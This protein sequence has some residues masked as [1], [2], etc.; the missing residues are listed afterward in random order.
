MG[1]STMNDASSTGILLYKDCKELRM[2]LLNGLPL[3]VAMTRAVLKSNIFS[4]V[5]GKD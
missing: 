3:G 5:K 2:E 1:V 4:K